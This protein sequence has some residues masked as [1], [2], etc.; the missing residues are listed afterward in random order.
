MLYDL[1]HNDVNTQRERDCGGDEAKVA[2]AVNPKKA[3]GHV[4]QIG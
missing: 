4:D 1:G 2:A 3:G